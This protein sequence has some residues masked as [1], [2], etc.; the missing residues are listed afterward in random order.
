M[1]ERL[2]DEVPHIESLCILT[3]WMAMPYI[4]YVIAD[5]FERPV[6][7]FSEHESVT[8]LPHFSSLT[9][10]STISIAFINQCVMGRVCESEEGSEK[11]KWKKMILLQWNHR[12]IYT[13]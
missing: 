3:Y 6:H 1:Y 13:F 11:F 10:H 2:L 9:R 4:G 5:T 8:F 12:D 7:L